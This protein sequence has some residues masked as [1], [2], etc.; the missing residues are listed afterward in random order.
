MLPA[1]KKILAAASRRLLVI[2]R[3]G[4][5]V[6]KVCEFCDQLSSLFWFSLNKE[7]RAGNDL[8]RRAGSNP[9]HLFESIQTHKPILPRLD[10][11]H[12]HSHL[13]Q[14]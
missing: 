12:W 11:Q 6:L 4:P 14:F 10:E 5:R 2:Y 7:M 9:L 13:L 3:L 8:R 1:A